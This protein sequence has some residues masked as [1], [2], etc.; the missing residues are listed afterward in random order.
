MI[1]SRL[2]CLVD[3]I[4]CAAGGVL[5]LLS[6][7]VWSWLTLPVSWRVP[8]AAL[9]LVFAALAATAYQRGT[10]QLMTAMVTGNI[11][12]I[13]AGAFALARAETTLGLTIIASVMIADAAMA[14]LQV[15]GIRT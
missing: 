8:T 7:T 6:P 1:S 15:S 12:W 11:V 9:L 10:N 4:G 14:W 3:A 13:L 2:A 5:L